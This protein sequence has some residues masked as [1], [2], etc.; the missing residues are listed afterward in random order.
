MT[1]ATNQEE[2]GSPSTKGIKKISGNR[3]TKNV[4]RIN[5]ISPDEKGYDDEKMADVGGYTNQVDCLEGESEED[6]AK[7]A[8]DR[9]HQGYDTDP[10]MNIDFPKILCVKGNCDTEG[11]GQ[12]ILYDTGIKIDYF[13]RLLFPVAFAVFNIVYWSYYLREGKEPTHSFHDDE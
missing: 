7:Y 11:K 9:H 13:C 12:E 4:Q 1:L 6:P 8:N 3:A 10:S 5:Q 2:N